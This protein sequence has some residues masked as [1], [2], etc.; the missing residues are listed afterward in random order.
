MRVDGQLYRTVWMECGVVKMIDQRLLPHRFT[1][2]DCPSHRETA[3]A[4]ANMTIRGAGAI[5]VAAG[6]AMAQAALEAPAA[7]FRA[8]IE[9]AVRT[10]RRT[11]PTARDLFYAVEQM[12]E[13]IRTASTVALA[14]AAP[15]Q[16][17]EEL[18]DENARA[19]EQMGWVV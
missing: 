9:E 6:Y 11:R 18:A 5:G 7:S 13:A 1:I 15:L 14:R 8:S 12:E 16:R 4:I 19:G 3:A 17:P 2:L 10:I